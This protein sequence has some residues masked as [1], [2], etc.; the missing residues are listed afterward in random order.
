[1]SLITI[2]EFTQLAPKAKNPD[3]WVAAMNSVLPS[4]NIT[5]GNRLAMFIAQCGHE[6]AGFT[7][8]QENL[9]YSADGLRKIFGKYFPTQELAQQYARQPEKIA[10]RVYANRMGNG[11]ES[12]GDGWKY[13]GRCS[14]QITGKSNY[15]NLSTYIW[16]DAS[17]LLNDPDLLLDEYISLHGAGW[18]WERTKLNDYCDRDDIVSVTKRI[19][20]GNHGSSDREARY[21][22]A[23]KVL[24]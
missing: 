3:K 22:A 11:D 23:K 12:S 2:E 15:T 6:S 21:A 9:N 17:I 14:I 10:N 7:V 4:Y 8:M 1:M 16:D 13:R 20:G 24:A 18:Y 5:R 19:N